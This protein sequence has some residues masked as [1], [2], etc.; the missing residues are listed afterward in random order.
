MATFCFVVT[1]S[2][3]A[4]DFL[5]ELGWVAEARKHTIA[6]LEE[7]AEYAPIAYNMHVDVS[8][9][10]HNGADSEGGDA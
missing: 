10:S 5:D 9:V 4:E 3:D 2:G 7:Y 8:P 1:V 6:A